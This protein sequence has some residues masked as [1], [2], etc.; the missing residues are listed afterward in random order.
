MAGEGQAAR[1]FMSDQMDSVV[2]DQSDDA[3]ARN[4]GKSILNAPDPLSSSLAQSALTGF[5]GEDDVSCSQLF[6]YIASEVKHLKSLSVSVFLHEQ[7]IPRSRH[8]PLI[9]GFREV[10][11]HFVQDPKLPA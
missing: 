9:Q 4:M 5:P 11:A 7:C 2:L 1:S 10:F 8:S 6:I 3:N